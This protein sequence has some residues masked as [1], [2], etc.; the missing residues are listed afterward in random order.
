M[1]F[2]VIFL[3]FLKS[4]YNMKA[5]SA[6]FDIELKVAID[7]GCKVFVTNVVSWVSGYDQI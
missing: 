6:A 3:A 5:L 1:Q 2:N 7:I 4:S